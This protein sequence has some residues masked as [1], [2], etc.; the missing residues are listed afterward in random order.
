M[1]KRKTAR[2]HV[3]KPG[4]SMLGRVV[5]YMVLALLSLTALYPL[6][7]MGYTSLKTNTQISMD[8]LALPAELHF[9]NYAAAWRTARIGQYFFN[10]VFVCAVSIVLTILISSL[11]ASVLAKFRFR[12]RDA[13]YTSFIFGMLIPLQSL[14]V[15]LFIL[16]RGLGLLDSLWSLILAYTA[17]GL[18]ISVFVLENFIAAL[19][20]A[21]LEAAL[22]DSCPVHKVFSSI[23]LPMSR[24][25]VATVIIINFLNN[26]KD[27][28][29]SLVFI[30]QEAKKTLP[31]GLYNFLGAE[32]S[33]YSGLTAALV[34]ASVPTIILYLFMQEQVISGVTTGAIRG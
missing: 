18:P 20:D 5:L 29:F 17:F 21:I 11:A 8:P 15:P 23:I 25:A 1:M 30:S 3:Q 32:T 9:E 16:M 33:N 10:S 14:L 22:I 26:W 19:P 6:I 7:W 4:K 28:S 34:I 12:G 2:H 31:L 24:P 27:F 13:I